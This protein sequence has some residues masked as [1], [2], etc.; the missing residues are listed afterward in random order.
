MSAITINDASNSLHYLKLGVFHGLSQDASANDLEK[1]LVQALFDNNN[2]GNAGAT[3]LGLTPGYLGGPQRYSHRHMQSDDIQ[4]LPN[5]D[6]EYNSIITISHII[7]PP[8]PTDLSFSETSTDSVTITPDLSVDKVS[9]VDISSNPYMNSSAKITFID[10]YLDASA[11]FQDISANFYG[12]FDIDSSNGSPPSNYVPTRNLNSQA[13]HTAN[14]VGIS[15]TDY[16]T[17]NTA[18]D[19]GPFVITGSVTLDPLGKPSIDPLDPFADPS[20]NDIILD[21]Y[22]TI[23]LSYNSNTDISYGRYAIELDFSSNST[24]SY[25]VSSTIQNPLT[26]TSSFLVKITDL[27]ANYD[28]TTQE[29]NLPIV[30]GNDTSPDPFIDYVPTGTILLPGYILDISSNESES[31]IILNR[32][33]NIN[34][35]SIDSASMNFPAYNMNLLSNSVDASLNLNITNNHVDITNGTI[36]LSNGNA[37]NGSIELTDNAEYLTQAQFGDGSVIFP[38]V[39]TM[40]GT[41][42]EPLYPRASRSDVSG[43]NDPFDQLSVI[44]DSNETGYLSSVG[45]LDSSLNVALDVSYGI[46]TIIQSTDNDLY[47]GLTGYVGSS[48]I[49]AAFV[50]TSNASIIPSDISFSN[51]NTDYEDGLYIFDLNGQKEWEENNIYDGTTGVDLPN[52]S[53][54]ASGTNIYIPDLRDLRVKLQAKTTANLS[55]M[56]NFILGYVSEGPDYLT[57]SNEYES[58]IPLP[59]IENILDDIIQDPSLNITFELSQTTIGNTTSGIHSQFN[60]DFQG[61]TSITYDDEI[62]V[63]SFTTNESS[64][65]VT[66]YT[67]YAGI[68]SGNRLFKITTTQSFTASTIFRFG[69][70]TNLNIITPQVTQIITSYRLTTQDGKQLPNRFLSGITNLGNNLSTT[71]AM[72]PITTRYEFV[73]ADLLPYT[74]NI[75]TQNSAN[76]WSDYPGSTSADFWYNTSSTIDISNGTFTFD[77]S[78]PLTTYSLDNEILYGDLSLLEGNTTFTA[79]GKY[80]TR[81][82]LVDKIQNYALVETDLLTY[83]ITDGSNV[84]LSTPSYTI[85]ELSIANPGTA[86][87]STGGYSFSYDNNLLVNLRI[88]VINRSIFNITKNVDSNVTSYLSFPEAGILK[89]DNGIYVNSTGNIS[90]SSTNDS[91]TWTL[92]N[93]YASVNLYNGYTSTTAEVSTSTQIDTTANIEGTLISNG[94]IFNWNRGYLMGQTDIERTNSSFQITIADY[95][96]TY[97]LYYNNTYDLSGG[98]VL[99]AELSMYASTITN[100]RWGLNLDTFGEYTIQVTPFTDASGSELIIETISAYNFVIF[101]GRNKVFVNTTLNTQNFNYR[102]NY[103]GSV[104]NVYYIDDYTNSSTDLNDPLWNIVSY[105]QE[106]DMRTLTN[107]NSIGN[108]LNV[109]LDPTYSITEELLYFFTISPPFIGFTIIDTSGDDITDIPFDVSSNY[110]KTFYSPVN[111]NEE[112]TP[113]N[114]S[115][116][117]NI[118]FDDNRGLSPLD[119][120]NATNAPTYDMIIDPYK[121]KVEL[122]QALLN[123]SN[124]YT[125]YYNGL[126]EDISTNYLE[127]SPLA[128]DGTFNLQLNQLKLIPGFE[129]HFGSG[130]T[131]IDPS[132]NFDLYNLEMRIGSAFINDGTQINFE[133]VAGEAVSYTT[134]TIDSIDVSGGT[135]NGT[136]KSGGVMTITIGKYFTD[137]DIATEYLSEFLYNGF[138]AGYTTKQTATIT[139][140]IPA[141]LPDSNKVTRQTFLTNTATDISN[142]NWSASEDVS[143]NSVYSLIPLTKQGLGKILAAYAVTKNIP[144]SVVLID[145]PDKINITDNGG[146]TTFRVKN[147]GAVSTNVL[148]LTS[149]NIIPY[150]TPYHNSA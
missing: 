95:S 114:G 58:V 22:I 12:H 79:S 120:F 104:F 4:I 23:D 117:N 27:S 46:Q 48:N 83:T 59:D 35:I 141:T 135:T 42:G 134:Y 21:G 126:I 143:N 1:G 118:T 45:V 30:V 147:S 89:V 148:S 150:N 19:Y 102:M 109:H 11:S 77:F 130:T 73:K 138:D 82:L 127:I 61:S 70:Y 146:N 24:S 43:N 69:Q 16:Y 93:D 51:T 54:N 111:P 57:S 14:E 20:L 125:Q 113:F 140:T 131:A 91:A 28:E 31:S 92:N 97:D 8:H 44:Y 25:S 78:A 115:N 50:S 132:S 3:R 142:I 64:L 13:A 84:I 36:N 139:R 40:S 88:I 32:N 122:K 103:G 136:T 52:I 65:E 144:I 10:Q 99:T 116:L 149:Q 38:T 6:L 124:N 129:N 17:W 34:P 53:F 74:L 108:I 121:I 96:N 101:E 98:L 94:V 49:A 47:S 66:N 72:T 145:T 39:N 37:D 63:G 80:L 112:Y 56:S 7:P 29:T 76:I 105:I 133:F 15:I 2:C 81:N 137:G 90:N 60:F 55:P 110:Y 123:I 87:L 86:T 128:A 26:D 107:S 71:I 62:E 75:Q 85:S 33:V 18:G 41:N 67:T 106:D 5:E 9:V 119:F 68:P 100:T